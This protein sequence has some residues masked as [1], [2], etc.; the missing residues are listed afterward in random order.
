[1]L[2]KHHTDYHSAIACLARW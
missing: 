1:M 2:P